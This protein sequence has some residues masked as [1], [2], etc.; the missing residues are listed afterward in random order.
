M[1]NLRWTESETQILIIT[2]PTHTIDQQMAL[3]PGRSY[4]AIQRRR[5]ILVKAGT[6]DP[7][8]CAYNRPWTPD[9]DDRAIE[10]LEGCVATAVVS[11]HLGRTPDAVRHR[12]RSLGYCVAGM[13]G[14]YSL[15]EV[16]ALFDVGYKTVSGV[17]VPR[18]WLVARKPLKSVRSRH[19]VIYNKNSH[20]FISQDN[21][22]A[23]I[24]NRQSWVWW[25]PGRIAH[26]LW[27]EIAQEVRNQ[28]SGRWLTIPD[29]AAQTSYSITTVHRWIQTGVLV[30]HKLSHQTYVWSEDLTFTKTPSGTWSAKQ[31]QE[32]A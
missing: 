9:E 5:S 18:G 32:A 14:E 17:W 8:Q 27:R 25:E 22:L 16:A 30:G 2:Y 10:M 24:E 13:R 4:L 31:K 15:K 21:V 19:R 6:L 29:V 1:Q 28:T 26:T 12:M 23:F 3:L 7:F 11:K 20:S